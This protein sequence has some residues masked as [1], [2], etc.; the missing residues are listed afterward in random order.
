MFKGEYF[1]N[2]Y[3]VIITN[4]P[5]HFLVLILEYIITLISQVTLFVIKF[6]FKMDDDIPSS[7]FYAIFIQ[8]IN[9]LP[10]YAK[11]LI[12]IIIFISIFACFF[13]YN[14]NR[15]NYKLKI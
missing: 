2:S 8:K 4:K 14:K 12:V 1:S 11:L 7:Y 9:K 5:F 3:K 13:I 10:E 6:N 15:L